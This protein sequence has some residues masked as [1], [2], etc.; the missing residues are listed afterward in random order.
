[1]D[2]KV[3][4]CGITNLDDA[5]GAAQAGADALGFIFAG[6][7]PRLLTLE[8]AA[9]I[10]R[11]LPSHPMRVGVFADAPAE[12]VAEAI[13]RCGLAMAQF[14]GSESP[15]FCAQFGVMSMKAFRVRDAAS[16]DAIAAYTVDAILLDTHVPGRLGGTGAVFDWTLARDARKFGKPV[17]LAGG[18]NADNVAGAL[19]VAEPFGVDVSSGVEAMP[20]KKDLEKVRRFIAAVRTA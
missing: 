19:R 17:F 16:L 9:A 1:M 20:G 4:I 7:S 12:F 3:K 2:V 18:L 14:H 10:S 8:A 5:L 6:G 15:E 11:Q 13:Q